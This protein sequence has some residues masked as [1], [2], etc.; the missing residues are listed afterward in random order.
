[1]EFQAIRQLDKKNNNNNNKN[2]FFLKKRMEVNL[3]EMLVPL[4]QLGVE[5]QIFL[6]TFS[7]NLKINLLIIFFKIFSCI[8]WI[9]VDIRYKMVMIELDFFSQF[10]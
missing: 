6:I 9:W 7:K 4:F 10:K 2:I 3:L 8:D 1:V 5:Q